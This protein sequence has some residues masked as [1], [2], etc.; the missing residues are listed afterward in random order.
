MSDPVSNVRT[1]TAYAIAA[2]AH[3]DWPEEWSELLPFLVNALASDSPDLI[4]GTLRV[5]IE[6]VECDLTDEQYSHVVPLMLPALYQIFTSDLHTLQSRASTISIM[7]Q[8]IEMAYTLREAYP[9][10]IQVLIQPA[11]N[12]W[13]PAFL[14]LWQSAQYGSG[15]PEFVLRYAVTK[16]VNKTLTMFP[17]LCQCYLEEVTKWISLDLI[18]MREPY[19][20]YLR[21]D[22]GGGDCNA[23][24]KGSIDENLSLEMLLFVELEFLQRLLE[25]KTKANKFLL[26]DN[27][28]VELLISIISYM[29]LSN[30]KMQ[31]WS[32]DP[33]QLIREEDEETFN[34][35]L[36]ISAADLLDIIAEHPTKVMES[37]IEA[38]GRILGESLARKAEGDL[39]WWRSA[40]A[41]LMAVLLFKQRI[42]PTTSAKILPLLQIVVQE[43]INLN[44]LPFL[45]GRILMFAAQLGT[46]LFGQPVQVTLEA[47]VQALGTS[48]EPLRVYALK[49]IE[50]QSKHT[51]AAQVV[52]F[53]T[54]LLENVA[55]IAH[56]CTEDMLLLTMDTII[57]LLKLSPNAAPQ[58]GLPLVQVALACWE[59]SQSDAI[60]LTA[61]V[62]LF[63]E[64]ATKPEFRESLQNTAIPLILN[65]MQKPNTEEASLACAVDVI[66]A[67]TKNLANPLPDAYVQAVFPTLMQLLLQTEDKEILQNGQVCLKVFIKQGL[68]SI[69]SW[70]DGKVENGLF[71]ILEFVG[72]LLGEGK[73]E[74]DALFLGQLIATL[75]NKGGKLLSP[76]LPD[77]LRAMTY[78]LAKAKTVTFI[79]SFLLVY[80]YVM[81]N[82]L[83]AMLTFLQQLS[84]NQPQDGLQLLIKVWLE[85]HEYIHG[86]LARKM[87][88]TS[89]ANLML[90]KHGILKEIQVKGDLIQSLGQSGGIKTRSKA[91]ANPD[92]YTLIP[93]DLKILKLL[94]NDGK[95]EL[96]TPLQQMKSALTQAAETEEGSDSEWETEDEEY[97]EEEGQYGFL[98][99]MID[100]QSEYDGDDDFFDDEDLKNDPVFLVKRETFLQQVMRQA[101]NDAHLFGY[102]DKL[103][104]EEQS[105]LKQLLA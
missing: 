67:V 99:D 101:A 51:D 102:F 33:S 52:P 75:V 81:R 55:R 68:P 11:I 86:S 82:D 88:C 40:E 44:D 10:V 35:S 34:Q 92:Q 1:A 50:Y 59:K 24:S 89:L 12:Q 45:Q 18:R 46:T 94:L 84:I 103:S 21:T 47:A 3:L 30:E 100:Q 96:E 64:L 57:A 74:S 77:L 83:E 22:G 49:A 66:A 32:D 23:K 70:T 79:Q 15:S 71:Y 7:G 58:L 19:A 36:R 91:K 63:E 28:L 61:V 97:A 93:A 87:S 76:V 42:T 73:S 43:G 41:C 53:Q 98:S 85:N 105:M 2:I 13:F 60:C 20:Q 95:F 38:F 39:E 9:E 29:Q 5:L 14:Q 26:K 17:K 69:I 31:E 62:D 27:I 56:H 6:F 8:F 4:H 16:T 104:M 80:A 78:R 65:I 37:I 48:S 54:I 72:K 25:K 90:L